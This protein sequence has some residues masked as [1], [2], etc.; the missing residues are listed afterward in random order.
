M[1]IKDK[2]IT[3][4]VVNHNK[5][6]SELQ[7]TMNWDANLDD[8]IGAFKTILIHQTFAEDSVKELFEDAIQY[9]LL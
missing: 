7:L 5:F 1:D 8:W 3:V 2:R 6:N 9:T 4:T